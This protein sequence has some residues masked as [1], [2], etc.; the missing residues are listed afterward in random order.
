MEEKLNLV[1]KKRAAIRRDGHR[2]SRV[3][4]S[5]C[6]SKD[7]LPQYLT[8]RALVTTATASIQENWS[9]YCHV[10]TEDKETGLENLR[11]YLENKAYMLPSMMVDLVLNSLSNV[12]SCN[13]L[14]YYFRN[15]S[16]DHHLFSPFN[17]H[18][19]GEIGIVLLNGHY[20][21]IC[22]MADEYSLVLTDKPKNVFNGNDQ[23]IIDLR[24]SPC[25]VGNYNTKVKYRAVSKAEPKIIQ[26]DII[27]HS[28]D[29]ISISSDDNESVTDIDEER[30]CDNDITSKF[31]AIE[32]IIFRDCKKYMDLYI[33]NILFIKLNSTP[34]DIN[35]L[36]VYEVPIQETLANCKGLR[37]L[38][39]ISN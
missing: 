37:T 15:E 39:H 19:I 31:K 38:V 25:K 33:F 20:G 12:S 30:F 8:Y 22:N 26:N 5:G 23:D 21:L 7:I 9:D 34:D 36:A 27:A 2:L 3:V 10:V 16:L 28:K 35:D 1:N 17:N 6:K 14:V 13:I 11:M 24:D 18:A 29:T 32:D 4:F